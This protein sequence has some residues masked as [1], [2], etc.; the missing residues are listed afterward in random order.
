MQYKRHFL[1][2][3]EISLI[4]ICCRLP[5]ATVDGLI[6]WLSLIETYCSKLI[7]KAIDSSFRSPEIVIG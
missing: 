6:N 2:H 5:G 7:D 4:R 1:F 3:I